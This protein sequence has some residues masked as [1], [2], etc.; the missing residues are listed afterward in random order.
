MIYTPTVL[1]PSEIFYKR[2]DFVENRR[3]W[4]T[5]VHIKGYLYEDRGLFKFSY[6]QLFI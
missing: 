5:K 3:E 1:P 2:A 6:T 4:V